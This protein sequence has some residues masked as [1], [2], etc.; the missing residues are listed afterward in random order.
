MTE[1]T[2]LTDMRKAFNE[3]VT[4]LQYQVKEYTTSWN[5]YDKCLVTIDKLLAGDGN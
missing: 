4:Q 5:E 2:E 3:F 1:E